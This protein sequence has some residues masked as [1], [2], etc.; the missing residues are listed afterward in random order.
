[1]AFLHHVAVLLVSPAFLLF[2]ADAA[3]DADEERKV[4]FGFEQRVRNENWNNLF[5]YRTIFWSKIPLSS[6]VDFF[7]SVNQETNQ[8]MAK[9]NQFDEVIVDNAYL[10]IKK[11]FTR[12]LS[13]RIGRQNITK[14]EGFLF[15]EG[16]PGDGSRAIYFNAVDLAYSRKKSKLEFIGLVDP[17]RD[18][19]LPR[20]HDQYK[21]LQDWDDQGMGVYYTDNNR[22]NT[23]IEA[24]YF[25]KKEV[26]D[27]MP[28][29]IP[30]FQPDRHVHTAGARVVQTLRPNLTATGEF[31]EQWGAQHPDVR[32]GAWGGYG[33][34]K[35]TFPN[36]WNSYVQGG[37]WGFSG[38]DPATKNK[39]ENWD[40]L[41]GRWP[42][43]SELYIYSQFKEVGVGYWTN[44]G[45]WQGETGFSPHKLVNCRLTY[46]HMN[47]FHPFPGDQRIFA[48]GTGRGDMYQGRADIVLNKNWKGHVLLE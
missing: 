29:S 1:M 44:T 24:Y 2:A 3:S 38:D 19:F 33:Y 26:H 7:A 5:D 20:I 22:K 42:K 31:A 39:I 27:V 34:L 23:G 21:V 32:I 40:P 4:E 30:Q 45:M 35:R 18:R 9:V 13:L 16:G 47:A 25:Y 37:Y 41:F 12:S 14:G 36:R 6:N 48:N 17:A 11:L 10:D 15:F 28:V 43:W 46:Y 8:K